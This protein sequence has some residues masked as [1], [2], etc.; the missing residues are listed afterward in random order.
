MRTLSAWTT[1]WVPAFVAILALQLLPSAV[2]AQSAGTLRVTVSDQ[3]GA[4]I[5]GAT[6]S[7]TDQDVPG[8][9]AIAGATNEVG[10]AIFTP[11]K[12]DRYTIQAEFPGFELRAV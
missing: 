10:L 3:T 4:I 6:V 2:F 12:P 5:V 11:L 1:R 9:A 8:S 7:V